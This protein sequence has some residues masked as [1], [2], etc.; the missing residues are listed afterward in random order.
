MPGL[1]SKPLCCPRSPAPRPLYAF[2]G[3]VD[4]SLVLAA[5]TSAARAHGVADPIPVT[6]RFP[7]ATWTDE[8]EWQKPVITSLGLAN[9]E[10][11]K[12][13]QDLDLL[14]EIAGGILDRHGLYYPANSH[15]MVPVAR[16]AAGGT[17]IT[18][19]GGDDV[20]QEWRWRHRAALLGQARAPWVSPSGAARR[21]GTTALGT[22]PAPLRRRILRARRHRSLRDP[23]PN[24]YRWL[25]AEGRRLVGEGL[26]DWDDQP[27]R[28]DQFVSWI[29][30]RR[31]TMSYRATLDAIAGDNGA[32]A[33]SP[34]ID[35]TFLAAIAAAGGRL[36]YPDR[37][38]AVAAIAG[39]R[40]PKATVTRKSK[41]VFHEVFWGERARAF[42]RAWDGSGVDD[43]LV[44]KDALRREWV[45]DRPDFRSMW[46]LHAVW[47]S[48]RVAA[49]ERGGDDACGDCEPG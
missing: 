9:W 5:A 14:G 48:Q 20:L 29:D 10:R 2:S 22:L 17:L 8:D 37:S 42:A 39:D 6:L 3:G 7:S 12:L 31:T 23:S 25:R 33:C 45:S 49:A 47:L 24:E 19:V 40:L 15:S 1:R 11:V 43:R 34:L 46:M 36:G 35:P 16:L 26:A 13:D 30:R 21:I 27:V 4:S 28:W 18:G 32:A 41:A 44:D 38:A